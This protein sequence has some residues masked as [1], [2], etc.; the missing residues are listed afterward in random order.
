MRLMRASLL[1]WFVAA[2][3]LGMAH[4]SDPGPGLFCH[5]GLF[6]CP[7]PES[8]VCFSGLQCLDGV[9]GGNG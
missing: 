5:E 3:A 8:G 7:C 1:S 2:M 4:C 6:G 9:C